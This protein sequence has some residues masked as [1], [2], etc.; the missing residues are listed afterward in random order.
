MS[1]VVRRVEEINA[2]EQMIENAQ[3][4]LMDSIPTVKSEKV[5]KLGKRLPQVP[6]LA[7]NGKLVPQVSVMKQ[8]MKAVVKELKN[9]AVSPV[10]FKNVLVLLDKLEIV[11]SNSTSDDWKLVECACEHA[12]YASLLNAQTSS[13][14]PLISDGNSYFILERGEAAFLATFVGNVSD[15]LSQFVSTAFVAKSQ[16]K[17]NAQQSLSNAIAKLE[18]LSNTEGQIVNSNKVKVEPALDFTI[19]DLLSDST[20]SLDNAS[21]EEMIE[22]LAADEVSDNE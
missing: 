5:E 22:M 8:F 21:S 10:L 7:K 14:Y 17:N 16:P 18:R 4:A 12:L 1:R 6:A 11:Q 2:L 19:D 13:G 9:D 3:Y 15:I 20:E